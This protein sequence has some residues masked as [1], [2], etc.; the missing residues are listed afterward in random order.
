MY[1]QVTAD[2]PPVVVVDRYCDLADCVEEDKSEV[3]YVTVDE[4][5]HTVVL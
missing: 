5:V 3:Q 1:L 4:H 2:A